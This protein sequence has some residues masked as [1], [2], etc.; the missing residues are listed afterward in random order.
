VL[1]GKYWMVVAVEIRG[2]GDKGGCVW[3]LIYLIVSSLK[4]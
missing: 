1:N 2:G 4:E 3:D